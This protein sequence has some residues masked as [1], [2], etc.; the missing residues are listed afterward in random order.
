MFLYP[1]CLQDVEK[2]EDTAKTYYN[3]GRLYMRMLTSSVGND[4]YRE[5]AIECFKCVSVFTFQ[6]SCV[7]VGVCAYIRV[8]VNT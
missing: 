5:Q 2:G 4:N 3:E 1:Q 6:K 8:F 7:G